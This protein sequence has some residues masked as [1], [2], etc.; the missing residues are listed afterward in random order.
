MRLLAVIAALLLS[1]AP[2]VYSCAV[3]FTSEGE[4]RIAFYAT[5]GFLTLLPLIMLAAGIVWVRKLQN[6]G[7]EK[8]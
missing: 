4:S 8:N 1:Y 2:P 7:D 6:R 3:C 5:T